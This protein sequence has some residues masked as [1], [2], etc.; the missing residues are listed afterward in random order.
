LIDFLKEATVVSLL[1]AA[2]GLVWVLFGFLV[3]S[4]YMVI[5]GKDDAS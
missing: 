1:L 2:I 4:L 5:S 3:Y